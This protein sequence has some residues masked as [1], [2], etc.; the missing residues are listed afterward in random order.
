MLSP[1]DVDAGRFVLLCSLLHRT[2]ARNLS[3]LRGK[4]LSSILGKL[5][6]TSYILIFLAA[7]NRRSRNDSQL[8]TS[9]CTTT[10]IFLHLELCPRNDRCRASHLWIALAI[11]PKLN[12][13]NLKKSPPSSRTR[14]KSKLRAFC[15][16]WHPCERPLSIFTA[17]SSRRAD[18]PPR[19]HQL[20]QPLH[21]RISR[22]F[23]TTTQRYVGI[24]TLYATWSP[25]IALRAVVAQTRSTSTILPFAV[26]NRHRKTTKSSTRS[27]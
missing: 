10:T 4:F 5:A 1:G 19:T 15:T 27:K 11:I 8:G 26:L 6:H 7:R 9:S 12:F 17:C 21:R 2:S 23:S 20:Y 14:R 13:A 22:K 25:Y 3:A 16:F 24:I 18:R